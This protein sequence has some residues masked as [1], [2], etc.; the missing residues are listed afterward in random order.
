MRNWHDHRLDYPS[1]QVDR[2]LIFNSLDN[3]VSQPMIP[4][5]TKRCPRSWLMRIMWRPQNM[6]RFIFRIPNGPSVCTLRWRHN[7]HAGVSNHQPLGCLLNRLF[8]RKSKKTPKLRV[9]GLCA[10][11]SP[12]TGEFP[13]QMASYAEN[14]SIWW[15]HHD[16]VHW[17]IFF[18]VAL[19]VLRQRQDFDY[20][21]R[22][23]EKKTLK[24]ITGHLGPYLICVNYTDQSS[25]FHIKSSVLYALVTNQSEFYAQQNSLKRLCDKPFTW[26]IHNNFDKFT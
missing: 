19:W 20:P 26:N 23:L 10:G 13:A 16:L 22:V 17:R 21:S 5:G 24:Y 11:N 15:R 1:L 14:V 25:S 2:L 8:R 3:L 18:R 12:G 9:T 7:D 6:L 4:G